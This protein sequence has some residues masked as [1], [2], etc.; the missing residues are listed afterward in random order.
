[1]PDLDQRIAAE[2][3]Q[4]RHR[5]SLTFRDDAMVTAYLLLEL[6]RANRTIVRLREV[7]TAA[8]RGDSARMHAALARVRPADLEPRRLGRKL[9]SR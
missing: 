1:M 4:R 6:R 7:V 5:R 3:E 2:D 9:P 8:L